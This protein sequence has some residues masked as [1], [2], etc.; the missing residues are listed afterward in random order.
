[1]CGTWWPITM[2]RSAPGCNHMHACLCTCTCTSA[3][4]PAQEEEQHQ[5]A[6]AQAE[7]ERALQAHDAA[8]RTA[9]EAEN[10]VARWACASLVCVGVCLVMRTPSAYRRPPFPLTHV[11]ARLLWGRFSPTQEHDKMS[12]H[13]ALSDRLTAGRTPTQGAPAPGPARSRRVGWPVPRRAQGGARAAA[14][15]GGGGP[16]AA[17]GGGGRGQALPGGRH[18]AA[19]G[20][21]G[22]RRGERWAQCVGGRTRWRQARTLLMYPQSHFVELRK[23]S[24]RHMVLQHLI[25]L[26]CERCA[27]PDLHVIRTFSTSACPARC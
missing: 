25:M 21:G 26:V 24:Q 2:L 17:Q 1:M 11:A 22:A 13:L 9:A 7:L 23:R 18:R 20:G 27:V 12:L 10:S 6:A 14:H 8:A 3:P 5:L 4:R 16:R 19:G 15:G